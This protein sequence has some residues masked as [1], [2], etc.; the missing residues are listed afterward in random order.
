MDWRVS[1]AVDGNEMSNDDIAVGGGQVDIPAA[2]PNTTLSS[3][4][5]M[6]EWAELRRKHAE[7][8]WR[9]ICVHQ[10]AARQHFSTKLELTTQ[11]NELEVL[12]LAE[13][14][15]AGSEDMEIRTFNVRTA[16]A[17]AK[18][19]LHTEIPK[20]NSRL[21][22]EHEKEKKRDKAVRDA[23]D[24]WQAADI[25]NLLTD[26]M[27]EVTSMRAAGGAGLKPRRDGALN[28]LIKNDTELKKKIDK[29]KT[30]VKFD[31]QRDGRARRAEH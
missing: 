29:L 9:F 19:Y 14:N 16:R 21:A 7:E 15:A 20:V 28:F 18:A 31:G 6:D 3:Y 10:D 13:L 5:V 4:S 22:K 25:K 1:A 24:E 23:D 11:Q 12:V 17:Y 2:Q 8:C 30:K 27:L 26:V